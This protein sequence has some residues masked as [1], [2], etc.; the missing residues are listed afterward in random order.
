MKSLLVFTMTFNSQ[1]M[2]EALAKI[3]VRQKI[4]KHHR[5]RPIKDTSQKC[6]PTSC[7]KHQQEFYFHD[8]TCSSLICLQCVTSE[9]KGHTFLTLGEAA[10]ICRNDFEALFT[11]C[12]VHIAAMSEAQREVET[13]SHELHNTVAKVKEDI[14]TFTDQLCAAVVARR[15]A[16]L[17]VVEKIR[18]EKAFVLYEQG[19]L[20]QVIRTNL[21]GNIKS[22]QDTLEGARDVE[23]VSM[24]KNLAAMMSAF[25]ANIPPLKPQAESHV[26]VSFPLEALLQSIKGAGSVNDGSTSVEK[27]TVS[28]EGLV[29]TQAGREAT[30]TITAR[31][32]EGKMNVANDAFVVEIHKTSTKQLEEAN[33]SVQSKGDGSYDVHY[34]LRESCEEGVHSVSVQLRGKHVQGSPFQLK[35]LPDQLICASVHSDSG[36]HS[37]LYPATNT[38]IPDTFNL[39]YAP[40]GASEAWIVYNLGTVHT[41]RAINFRNNSSSR[42]GVKAAILQTSNSPTGPWTNV[43]VLNQLHLADSGPYKFSGFTGSGQYWRLVMTEYGSCTSLCWFSFYFIQFFGY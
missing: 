13:V 8:T 6:V 33:M 24:N 5:V 23:V 28:G 4:L 18:K 29:S 20:L 30:F 10:G 16:L 19:D 32:K 36:S 31:N 1:Y 25:E 35:V 26:S 40:S 41:I 14:C 12:K 27:T 37:S 38:L 3:H 34:K 9:H 15:E 17:D 22:I 2:C 7:P 43:Q 11:N 21:E 42:C 39:Y